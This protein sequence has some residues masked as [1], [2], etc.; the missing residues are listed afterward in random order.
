MSARSR[1]QWDQYY[2]QVAH[3]PPPTPDP[4]LFAFTPPAPRGEERR[5]L[6]LA[7]GL[8]QNGL[9]LARQGY[10]VDLLDISREA[11][12]QAQAQAIQVAARTVNFRQADLDQVAL[13]TEAYDLVCVFRFLNRDLIPHLRAAVCAGGRVIYGSYNL[14]Y[15]EQAPYVQAD[16][17]LQPGELMDYFSGW[18]VLKHE[19]TGDFSQ[20]VAVCPDEDAA[21]GEH[22]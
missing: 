20:I 10:A 21:T 19:E 18:R 3:L 4:I 13:Q 11:L 7:C 14:G 1:A 2:R 9:W 16:E 5:A 12:R 6:D 17:L 22:T 15:L 8:G